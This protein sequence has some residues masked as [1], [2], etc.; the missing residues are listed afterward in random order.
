MLYAKAISQESGYHILDG[1]LKGSEF[2]ISATLQ[3]LSNDDFKF[4]GRC[5]VYGISF[6]YKCSREFDVCHG[7]YFAGYCSS[8][9]Y[10]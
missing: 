2:S 4:R 5:K 6:V 10:G 3:T 1:K 9:E 7:L 8:N